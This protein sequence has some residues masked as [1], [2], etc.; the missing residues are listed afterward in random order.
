M[1]V[2]TASRH[3]VSGAIAAVRQPAAATGFAL[4]QHPRNGRE[5]LSGVAGG[6]EESPAI[7]MVAGRERHRRV[8]NLA[9]S[10]FTDATT[11]VSVDC[12]RAAI[13]VLAIATSASATVL[14]ARDRHLRRP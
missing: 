10:L 9:D 14:I 13:V 4:E 5:W 12:D 1:N 8:A 2:T 6:I 7:K 11:H 3:P